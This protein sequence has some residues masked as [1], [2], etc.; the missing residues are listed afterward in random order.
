M[1]KVEWSLHSGRTFCRP[2]EAEGNGRFWLE[3]NPT[4]VQSGKKKKIGEVVADILF[5]GGGGLSVQLAGHWS[6]RLEWSRFR[7]RLWT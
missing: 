5:N 3:N 1:E 4:S 6:L 2:G 7:A